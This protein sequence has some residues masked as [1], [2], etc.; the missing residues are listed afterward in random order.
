VNK[1]VHTFGYPLV[2]ANSDK[3]IHSRDVPNRTKLYAA[4]EGSATGCPSNYREDA[5]MSKEGGPANRRRLLVT[6]LAILVLGGIGFAG[7]AAVVG[8]GAAVYWG[9]TH[10][11]PVGVILGVV[12]GV[13]WLLV[14]VLDKIPY[15]PYRD[16]QQ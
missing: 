14:G 1:V 7:F 6:L 2:T 8:P 9:W 13:W 5:T 4:R 10:L 16:R 11:V 12:F 3:I 15:P